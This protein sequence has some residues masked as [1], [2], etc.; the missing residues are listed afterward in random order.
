MIYLP[1]NSDTWMFFVDK[2][3]L[4]GEWVFKFSWKM[5]FVWYWGISRFLTIFENMGV[6][7]LLSSL[8]IILSPSTS[9]ISLRDSAVE[10]LF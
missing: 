8:E 5:P 6:L 10:A 4:K 9:V 2:G 3:N 1:G 7:A